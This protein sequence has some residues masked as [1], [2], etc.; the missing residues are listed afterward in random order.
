MYST[1]KFNKSFKLANESRARYRVMLGS[2]GSGKSVDVAQDY[3]LKLMRPEFAGCNLLCVRS[4]EVTHQNS[5]FAEL[6]QAIDR[7]GATSAWTVRQNP[8]SLVC[9]ATGNEV[10][11]R[12]CNDARALER[13]KSV[14]AKHGKITWVWI[15]EATELTQNAFEIIDDRLRGILPE[16][17]YYQITLTFNPV[18]AQHWI[19][20]TLWDWQSP[21][22]FTH[23][24]TYLENAFI[25][26]DYKRRMLRRKEVD[27]EGYQ[28]YGLGNWGETGGLI[29]TATEIGDYSQRQ[30]DSYTIGADWGYNHLTAVLLVGWADGEPYIVKEVTARLKTTPEIIRMCDDAGMPKRIPMYADS[31]EPDRI[32]EFK[33]AGY[34]VQPVKKEPNSVRN[35]IQW[36]KDRVIHVDGRCVQLQKELQQYKWLKD[37]ST[38]EYTDVPVDV[39]DDCIA[40]LRYAIEP[41]RKAKGLRTMSKRSLSI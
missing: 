11:F 40:A 29:F 25:D 26:D 33:Q 5:T 7:M 34:R 21:D 3:V 10:I 28:V 2:A 23:K 22:I 15:E 12:G 20:R 1:A 17:H 14:Q 37:R 19:K 13:L 38:G 32:K 4:A 35:Q 31:A 18:S 27:P 39:F 24:S 36:L 30:F 8:L 9:N 41:V 6:I 16:G